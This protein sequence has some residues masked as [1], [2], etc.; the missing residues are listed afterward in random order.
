M[1]ITVF[2][3]HPTAYKCSSKPGTGRAANSNM[4]RQSK[5]TST[6]GD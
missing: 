3:L 6:R 2:Q 5:G 1:P 4:K